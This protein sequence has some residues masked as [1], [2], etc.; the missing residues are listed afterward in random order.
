MLCVISIST[1]FTLDLAELPQTNPLQ[2]SPGNI[3]L[4]FSE[5]DSR[6][7]SVLLKWKYIA[8]FYLPNVRAIWPV[9]FNCI[10]Y[11]IRSSRIHITPRWICLMNHNWPLPSPWWQL[12]PPVSKDLLYFYV[13]NLKNQHKM[14]RRGM[15]ISHFIYVSI[16]LSDRL[17]LIWLGGE[18]VPQR[19]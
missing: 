13:N 7:K 9:V 11:Y 1:F 12:T 6:G 18:K 5:R 10:E 3:R 15:I 17:N 14:I 4:F 16:Y 8:V 2:I 19:M